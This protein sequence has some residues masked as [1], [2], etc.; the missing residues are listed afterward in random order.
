MPA[1][2]LHRLAEI[3]L[4]ERHAARGRAQHQRQ[5]VGG[6]PAGLLPGFVGGQQQHRAGAVKPGKLARAQAGRRQGGG[7]ST[8]AAIF[9]RWRLTSKSDTGR[10]AVRPAR[11]PSAF[12][13]QPMPKAVTIPAPVMTTRGGAARRRRK[14]E[15]HGAVKGRREAG[16]SRH[17]ALK[18]GVHF[19]AIALST[20]QSSHNGCCRSFESNGCVSQP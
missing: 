9:T 1:R 18:E 14:G 10:N 16:S 20:R 13:F 17:D 2:R 4:A 15:K 3:G 6:F 12:G 7:K 19:T 11:N 5:I 8:S